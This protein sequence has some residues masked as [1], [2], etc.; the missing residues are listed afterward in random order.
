PRPPP[1]P[2]PPHPHPPATGITVTDNVFS[3]RY[4]RNSGGYG[5]VTAWDADGSGNVWRGN[6]FSHGTPITPEPAG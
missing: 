1:H 3:T 4:H 6:R 5:A 2:P